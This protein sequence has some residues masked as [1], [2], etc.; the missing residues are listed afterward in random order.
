MEYLFFSLRLHSGSRFIYLTR[1]VSFSNFNSVKHRTIMVDTHTRR[2]L[3]ENR[4][5]KAC[6]RSLV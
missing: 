5:L 2:A 1:T 6:L 4:Q 3:A